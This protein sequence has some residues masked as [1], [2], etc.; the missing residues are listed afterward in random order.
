MSIDEKL[1]EVWELVGD[2]RRL[3]LTVDNLDQAFALVDALQPEPG[4]IN[5]DGMAHVV[6]DP[7]GYPPG[8][9]PD[10]AARQRLSIG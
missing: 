3:L 1:Y 2:V 9:A 5:I 7:G 10:R 6:T 4:Q 8:Q